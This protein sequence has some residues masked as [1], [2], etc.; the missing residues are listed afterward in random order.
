VWGPIL[1]GSGSKITAIQL[2]LGSGQRQCIVYVD[3]LQ[4]SFYQ[5]GAVVDFAVPVHNVD[6]GEY[7]AT[8]QEAINDTDTLAGHTVYVSAGIYNEDVLL[9]RRDPAGCGHRPVDH[10]GCEERGGS[11]DGPDR[12]CEWRGHR[13]LHDHPRPATMSL[14]G[15]PM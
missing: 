2:G 15:P 4:A 7:F 12:N 8:I 1:F 11:R 9:T 14:I 10:H 6:T 3:Y 13:R 5:G